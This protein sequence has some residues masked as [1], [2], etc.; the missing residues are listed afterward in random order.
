MP[1]IARVFEETF[2]AYCVCKAW[3]QFKASRPDALWVSGF[4]HVATWPGFA[5]VAFIIDP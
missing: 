1:E 4:T 5:Y 2:R 3:R